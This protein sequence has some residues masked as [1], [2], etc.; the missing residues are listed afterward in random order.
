MTS[1]AITPNPIPGTTPHGSSHN[2][3]DR[4]S[5]D[6]AKLLAR[7]IA[8]NHRL[9]IE[10]RSFLMRMDRVEGNSRPS[11]GLQ[12][13]L[14]ELIPGSLP[15]HVSTRPWTA[16][17]AEIAHG[18]QH[19]M[20]T[21]YQASAGLPALLRHCL[22]L[23][24]LV[25]LYMA[26]GAIPFERV[27]QN[28]IV[29]LR[30]HC[31][32]LELNRLTA[33]DGFSD[34]LSEPSRSQRDPTI[35]LQQPFGIG[36]SPLSQALWECI[37]QQGPSQGS[38]F[39][40]TSPR[41]ADHHAWWSLAH[42]L[43]RGLVHISVPAEIAVGVVDWDKIQGHWMRV[44]DELDVPTL[45]K[46]PTPTGQP[47]GTP[48]ISKIKGSE[49]TLHPTQPNV[50]PS[51]NVDARSSSEQSAT[52]A[53]RVVE[54]RSSRDP[55][56]SANLDHVLA[57]CRSEQTS[58]SL[59]VVKRLTSDDSAKEHVVPSVPL[60]PWHTQFIDALDGV[61][62]SPNVRAF[63]TDEGELSIV[64]EDVERTELSGWVREVFSSL[65]NQESV[66][67]LVRSKPEPLVAGIGTVCGPSKS[68]RID[69]LIQAAWRCLDGA[70]VQGAGAVKT[71]E[72][73]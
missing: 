59:I 19:C 41:E 58:L 4:T 42:Q 46:G 24:P 40:H 17:R 70:S 50:A 26:T 32:L 30:D 3:P 34:W 55:Q 61:A 39:Q 31:T 22:C 7:Y 21:L 33:V 6:R 25:P 66:S 15:E 23:K 71:I 69:Q 51:S 72:V 18:F 13:L 68:F 16:A 65:S 11:D 8:K 35:T 53:H 45:G 10:L 38:R 28:A 9:P 1:V 52:V 12:S 37:W 64:F 43:S 56:L 73:Y 2:V 20:R 44:V 62:Q 48:T 5:S 36:L 57:H 67:E 60:Q 63:L 54:I 49:S 27:V 29:L 47:T 14:L